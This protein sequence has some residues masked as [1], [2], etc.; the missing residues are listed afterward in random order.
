M[1]LIFVFNNI[2][3]ILMTG[4]AV[5]A[6]LV[7][8]RFLRPLSV[9]NISYWWFVGIAVALY[10]FY[11]AFVT[12]GQ[13]YV[14]ANGNELTKVFISAP[15]PQEA[16]L[17]VILEWSRS[18]FEQPLGY[19]TYY[20]FGRIW[21]NITILFI[22]SLLFYSILKLWSF[23]KGGFLPNGLEMILALLLVVGYPGVLILIPLGFIL[24]IIWFGVI[25]F[26]NRTTV[27]PPMYIEPAF[28][29]ATPIALFFA[30]TFLNY[31]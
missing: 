11:G 28:L 24:A 6:I 3:T 4:L 30:K 23:Y 12:W 8:M 14:W 21:L 19:F 26:K 25:Y 2:N 27:Q 20:V 15:L 16:P 29:I 17:P 1:S 13:Y 31:L 5:L 9:K 18:S 22:V 10:L 7:A